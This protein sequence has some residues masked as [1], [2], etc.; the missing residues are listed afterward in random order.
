MNFTGVLHT[1]TFFKEPLSLD[2]KQ[3]EPL[4]GIVLRSYIL[5]VIKCCECM[6]AEL[7]KGNIYEVPV[8]QKGTADE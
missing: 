1:A 5:G 4:V 2:S 6:V 8:S 7:R 3:G